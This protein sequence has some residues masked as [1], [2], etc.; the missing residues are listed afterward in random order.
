MD[1]EL[2]EPDSAQMSVDPDAKTNDSFMTNEYFMKQKGKYQDIV[3]NKK[4]I[5][6]A[7]ANEDFKR[8]KMI[9]SIDLFKFEK[10][11]F[12][13]MKME[14]DNQQSFY[15]RLIKNEII[16]VN[17]QVKVIMQAMEHQNFMIEDMRKT[18]KANM[19]GPINSIMTQSP[20]LR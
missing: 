10:S 16:S 14:R 19:N 15:H 8:N 18:I 1:E 4:N 5:W 12:K 17:D 3:A 9:E 11:D 13:R 6:K 2:S 20:N 7:K